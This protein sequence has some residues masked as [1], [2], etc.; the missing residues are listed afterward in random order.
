M[1]ILGLTGSIATGKST[2][3]D[4]FRK[5]GIPV[6]CA[7]LLA[8]EAVRRDTPALKKIAR[9]FGKSMITQNG[10]LNRRKLGHL[11]FNEAKLRTKLNAIVHP[12]VVRLFRQHIA[13]HKKR[14]TP[15]IV[16]DIPL[17]FEAKLENLCDKIMVVAT[18]P[19]QQLERLI[20]RNKMTEMEAKARIASQIP[21]EK[22]KKWADIVIDNSQSLVILKKQINEFLE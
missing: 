22:K 5:K 6:I 19:R 12:E 10:V 11:I 20:K 2:V 17:L 18:T 3:S 4:L 1:V 9:V 13:R 7:D 15:M 16:L 21:I 8:R 14:H